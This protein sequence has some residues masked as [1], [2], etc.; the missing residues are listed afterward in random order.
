MLAADSATTFDSPLGSLRLVF[1]EADLIAL[2]LPTQAGVSCF[3][4]LPQPTTAIAAPMIRWLV[5]YFD[6]NTDQLKEPTGIAWK[7]IG[8]AFQQQVWRHLITIPYGSLTTYREV[9]H[10]IGRPTAVR[11]VANAIGDNPFSIL[12]PCHR[13]IGV[14]GALTGYAGGLPAK[15][16]LLEHEAQAHGQSAEINKDSHTAQQR[17][18]SEDERLSF[19][20]GGLLSAGFR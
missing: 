1:A 11:A 8:T 3:A 17:F 13:V 7:W 16:W 15:R 5:D 12:I 4:Q 2:Y 19:G 10:A 20:S 14:S 6:A 18:W 9:A